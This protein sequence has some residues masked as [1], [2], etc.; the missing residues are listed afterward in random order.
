MLMFV[1]LPFI[2]WMFDTSL[3]SE[4]SYERFT[5]AFTAGIGRCRAGWS[6]SWR[7]R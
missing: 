2:V 5:G 1:L 4:V 7:W 3:S 6:S